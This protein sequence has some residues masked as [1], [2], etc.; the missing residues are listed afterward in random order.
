MKSVA[1][2]RAV[3]IDMK[4]ALEASTRPYR[5]LYFD[6]T[7]ILSGGEIALLN[8]IRHADRRLV[9]PIVVLCSEG[10][11][12]ERLREVCEVHVI[13]LPESLRNKRKD[14]L[15]WRSA[16]KFRDVA[17]LALY[18]FRLSGFAREHNIDL[19]HTNSLKAD[20]IGGVAGRL[21]KLPVVWHVHDRIEEDYLPKSMVHAFRFL[22]EILPSYVIT[23][24]RAVLETLRLKQ[25]RPRASIP[26]G[27]EPRTLSAARNSVGPLVPLAEERADR[28]VVALIGRICPWKGQHIFLEA[29]AAVRKQFPNATFKIVGAA[30][31]GEQ[32]Y[33]AKVRRLCT[34]LNLDGAV[35]FTGF[36]SNVPELLAEVDLVVHASTSAEPFGQVIIEGMAAAKPIVATNG[37]GVPE[38]VIDNVTGLLV[39]MSDAPGMADAICKMLSDPAT[40]RRMGVRGQDRVRDHFSIESTALKVEAVYREVLGS[41]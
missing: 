20:V 9:T 13:P 30:L 17:A 40:A 15:G 10:P 2:K 29:A 3:P 1:L 16:L 28:Q 18:T 22:C 31:F 27:V 38:I 37:G 26:P 41:A 21:A 25:A 11:L 36:C 12:A 19:I 24:S 4:P 14:S 7:A 39:P 5:I 32:Q 23:N 33:E 6:H 8:L 35:E 34:A